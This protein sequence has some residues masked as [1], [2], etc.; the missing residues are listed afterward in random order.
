MR[1]DHRRP[2][3]GGGRQLAARV[4]RRHVRQPVRGPVLLHEQRGHADTVVLAGGESD[5]AFVYRDMDLL[6]SFYSTD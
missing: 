4:P 3:D 6:F 5:A 2:G 1:P